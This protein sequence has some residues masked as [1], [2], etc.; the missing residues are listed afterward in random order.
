MHS[1]DQIR[2]AER[3]NMKLLSLAQK[4]LGFTLLELLVVI[5]IIGILIAIG[6][7]SFSTAQRQGRDA[8]R[9]ADMKT[10]QN[11]IE[12]EKAARTTV[13]NHS[14]LN[15]EVTAC[16]T[17]IGLRD[18]IGTSYSTSL[19]YN[20]GTPN[21]TIGYC[22]AALLDSTTAGNCGGCSSGSTV[23][24]TTHFCVTELQ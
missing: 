17:G 16:T 9:R 21:L 13:T 1:G 20:G 19:E 7:A 4:K 2:Y 18:P 24:G 22:A 11:C 10:F 6:V 14:Y 23:S 5:S 8:R 12:Q 3:R 15:A